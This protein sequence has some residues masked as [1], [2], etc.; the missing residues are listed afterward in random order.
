[1]NPSRRDIVRAGLALSVFACFGNRGARADEPRD[2]PA[3]DNAS[4]PTITIWDDLGERVS[5]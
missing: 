1:M 2:F 4:G 5:T 3:F